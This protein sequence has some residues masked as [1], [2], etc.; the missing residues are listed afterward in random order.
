M[1]AAGNQVR[2]SWAQVRW[3]CCYA[4]SQWPMSCW[5]VRPAQPETPIP[6]G[7]RRPSSAFRVGTYGVGGSGAAQC[8]A[9]RHSVCSAVVFSSSAC[10]APSFTRPGQA[11]M[12][13]VSRHRHN[14]CSTRPPPVRP[15]RPVIRQ[16]G[17]SGSVPAQGG[18]AQNR[19]GRTR[20]H[21][22]AHVAPVR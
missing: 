7:C 14:P 20:P 16:A 2:I 17:T 18:A 8:A 4:A 6:W 1:S 11:A 9:G 22:P 21:R 15:P 12:A 13:F 5:S 3:V 10:G 19:G